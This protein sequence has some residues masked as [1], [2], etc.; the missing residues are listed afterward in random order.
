MLSKSLLDLG[1]ILALRIFHWLK[2]VDENGF[3]SHARPVHIDAVN[4]PLTVVVVIFG[5]V[6][7]N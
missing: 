4:R 3:I 7:T 6:Q 5:L 2:S 1:L